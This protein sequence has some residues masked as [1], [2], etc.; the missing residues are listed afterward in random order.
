MP[1]NRV[2]DV[3]CWSSLGMRGFGC[4]GLASCSLWALVSVPARQ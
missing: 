4:I 3:C 1:L 2:P